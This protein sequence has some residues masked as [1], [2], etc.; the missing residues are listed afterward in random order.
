M[1]DKDLFT[2]HS[3]LHGC[4][5]P[6]DARSQGIRSH[7]IDPGVPESSR[8]ITRVINCAVYLCQDWSQWDPGVSLHTGCPG[9]GVGHGRRGASV[10]P[11]WGHT[12][13]T[14]RQ[15]GMVAGTEEERVYWWCSDEKFY[16]HTQFM[17]D[18]RF[19]PSQWETVLLCSEVFHW[20]GANLE[21]AL[22]YYH[23]S[24]LGWHRCLKSNLVE[25][26]WRHWS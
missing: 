5:W 8:F 22:I 1:K 21:S 3:Q 26:M 13:Q 24:K 6:S 10:V 20:L 23:F 2:L 4:W 25:D 9:Y 7:G 18:S 15:Q 19:A 16:L 12:G 14:T 11:Y 17:V